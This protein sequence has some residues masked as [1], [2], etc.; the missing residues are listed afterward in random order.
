MHW[1]ILDAPRK[2]LL[3]HLAFA[4][5]YGF[6]LAGG[7]GLA[8]QLG[9][10]T[11]IDFDFFSGKKFEEGEFEKALYDNI[12]NFKVE[13]KGWQTFIGQAS[14]IDISFFYYD[15]PLLEPLIKTEYLNILPVPDIAAM[16][17]IALTDRGVRRDFLDLYVVAKE[18]GLDKIFRWTSKKFPHYDLHFCIKALT[19]F[20][21][22]EKDAS[23]RGIKLK[24]DA[25]WA[26]IKNF[27]MRETKRLVK[28]WL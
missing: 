4:K 2:K 20:E 24:E 8:L 22:A 10:R 7:T 5:T 28:I 14:K 27:L 9:H 25:S 19:Y 15:H 6:Y 17:L 23:G 12:K 3:P 21:D 26:E 13:R 1:D 11:S 16:K 18:H